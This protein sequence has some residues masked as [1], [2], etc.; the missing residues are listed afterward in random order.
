MKLLNGVL[1]GPKGSLIPD[2]P[3]NLDQA[4]LFKTP[5]NIPGLLVCLIG[6]KA[7]SWDARDETVSV[8][9]RRNG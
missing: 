7:V 5:I 4:L 9:P 6:F 8:S 2:V 3:D 1:K